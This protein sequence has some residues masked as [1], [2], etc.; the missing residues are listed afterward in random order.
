MLT[1]IIHKYSF[2]SAVFIAACLLLVITL[3]QPSFAAQTVPYKINFQGR[4]TGSDANIVPDGQYNMQYRI[5]DA[6]SGGN[7]VWNELREAGNR[8]QV[9]N[10]LFAVQL[11]DITPINP[12]LFTS[13][14]LYFEV[15]LPSPATATCGTASCASF[16]EGPMTPRQKLAASPYAMNAD[17]V[18]G[19]DGSEIA[20]IN[21]ENTFT[22]AQEININSTE[23]LNVQT[24][25]NSLL[26]ADTTNTIVKIGTTANPTLAN[27]RLISTS[28]EFTGSVRVGTATN[29]VDISAAN[30][31]LLN[32]T[33][34]RTKAITIPAEYAGAVLDAGTMSANSG[35]M[36][37]G[38]D[39]TN[40]MNYYNWTTAEGSSQTYDV[41]VQ[42]PIPSDFS[43]WANTN[44]ISIAT[45]SSD[46][47]NGL[48]SVEARD[49]AG[50]VISGVN[51][52]DITPGTTDTWETQDVGAISGTFS[53]GEYM[54]LRIRMQANDGEQ[55][56]IGNINLTYLS[57]W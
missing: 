6:P 20:V 56:R 26:L 57:R 9:T 33:A 40:R 42:V 23:A 14:D 49:T 19:I 3:S 41:V 39:L 5:Y 16:T 45:H 51:F 48:I 11:G 1:R 8:V 4:L 12:A 53:S 24:G 37:A 18:D 34:R 30:G 54:T 55:V 17:M 10:G 50:A 35:A 52:T 43:D 25:G 28:A 27:V 44:P 38:F 46:L 2:A 13:Q 15:E 32:G 21:D 36:T 29:G 22:A 47:T 31:V 7:I